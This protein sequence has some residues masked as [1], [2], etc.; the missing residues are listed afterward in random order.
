M[1]ARGRAGPASAGR[2]RGLPAWSGGTPVRRRR[3]WIQAPSRPTARAGTDAR[4]ALSPARPSG[5]MYRSLGGELSG[6]PFRR[7]LD[8]VPGEARLLEAPD[9]P[10]GR[11]ELPGLEA[12]ARG[13]RERVVV[14]VPRLAEREE[15]QPEQ[16]ARLVAGRELPAPEEVAERVDAVGRV[17]QDE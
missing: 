7:D 17:V 15:R 10:R 2:G 16:V 4:G 12:V 6:L 13:R 8:D 14:V 5:P 3:S 11:V 9:H 1:R